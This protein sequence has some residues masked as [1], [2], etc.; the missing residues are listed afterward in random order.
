[1]AAQSRPHGDHRLAFR[2]F[3]QPGIERDDVDLVLRRRLGFHQRTQAPF[4]DG[5]DADPITLTDWLDTYAENAAPRNPAVRIG[6]V[7]GELNGRARLHGLRQPFPIDAGPDAVK[8]AIGGPHARNRRHRTLAGAGRRRGVVVRLRQQGQERLG[9]GLAQQPGRRRTVMHAVD[10]KGPLRRPLPVGLAAGDQHFGQR[11][12]VDRRNALIVSDRLVRRHREARAVRGHARQSEIHEDELA[13]RQDRANLRDNPFEC[14]RNEVDQ[15]RC[16]VVVRKLDDHEI[17][18]VRKHVG[19]DAK[20]RT[21]RH[22]AVASAIRQRPARVGVRRLQSCG[23]AIEVSS[24]ERQAGP[25][26]HDAHG[27]TGAQA[28]R[29]T[30][31][32]LARPQQGVHARFASSRK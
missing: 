25:K 9:E 17:G 26:S 10:R 6:T 11:R 15:D 1:M 16:D 23:K 2:Q 22:V 19:V 18:R 32:A 31:D 8:Q 30:R 3:L 29:G 5:L 7:K 14:R 28:P 20:G 21:Q 24:A 27:L 4:A 12:Q 13:V